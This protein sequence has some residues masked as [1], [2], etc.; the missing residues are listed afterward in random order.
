MRKRRQAGYGGTARD[1]SQGQQGRHR[2]DTPGGWDQRPRDRS[3][4]AQSCPSSRR[5]FA[6]LF[7]IGSGPVLRPSTSPSGGLSCRK[8]PTNVRRDIRCWQ[9][10]NPDPPDGQSRD[11]PHGHGRAARQTTCR[12][13]RQIYPHFHGKMSMHFN[14]RKQVTR[15]AVRTILP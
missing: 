15:R 14:E 1:K 7:K 2:P 13:T 8:T 12:R 10:R 5:E 4:P 11:R 9:S 3:V 6:L